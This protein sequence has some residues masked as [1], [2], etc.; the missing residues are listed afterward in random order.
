[1]I[2]KVQEEAQAKNFD[3]LVL[4]IS[5]KEF[6]SF[7]DALF[8]SYIYDAIKP[9]FALLFIVFA[10]PEVSLLHRLDNKEGR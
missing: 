6:V 3:F 5:L 7:T 4:K 9:I 2:Q 10:R 1:M 8:E